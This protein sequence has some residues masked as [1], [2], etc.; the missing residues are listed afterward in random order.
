MRGVRCRWAWSWLICLGA[1]GFI[2]ERAAILSADDA[3]V[4]AAAVRQY[5]LAV[6]LQNKKLYTQAAQKWAAF[7]QGF[8]KDP[9]LPNAH[10]YLGICQ[11]Q[12]N[13]LPEAA[14]SFR[15]VLTMFPTFAARDASQY[16]LGLVLFN[17]AS[18]SKKPEDWKAALDAFAEVNAKFAESKH[19]PSALFYQGEC[20]FSSGD[21][22]AALATYQKF[23]AAYPQNPLLPEVYY[24]LGTTQQG[25]GSDADAV[26]TFQTLVQKFPTDPQ[27]NES[28]LRVGMSQFNQKKYAEAEPIFAQLAAVADFPLADFALLR[29]AQSLSVRAQFPQAAALYETLPMKFPKSKLKGGALLAAGQSWFNA[30]Q[31]PQAQKDLAAVTTEQAEKWEEAPEAAYWLART[32]L[33]LKKPLEAVAELDRAI[34]A[35]AASSFLPQLVFGRIDALYEVPDRQKETVPLFLDFAAKYPD[36]ETAPKALDMAGLA[37]LQLGDFAAAQKHS[38]AFL[39]NAKLAKHELVPDALYVGGESFL[40]AK[41]PDP[42]QAE[43]LFRRLA[44]E[45]PQHKQTPSARVRIGLALH[46]A[47]KYDAAVAH[48]TP[49]VAELKDPPLVAETQLL[50]GRCHSDAGRP[51]PAIIAFRAALVAKPDWDRGDEVLLALAASLHSQKK[52]AE[53]TIELNKLNAAYAQSPFRDQALYQLAEIAYEEKK[54]P[55]AAAH[56]QQVVAQFPKGELAAPAQYGVG[57]SLYS[58]EDFEQAATAFTALLTNWPQSELASKGKFMRGLAYRRL[59]KFDLA[60]KDL[61]EFL[62]AKPSE[63]DAL[64]ARYALALCQVGLKQ[65]EPAATTLAAIIKDKPDYADVDKVYYEMAYALVELKKT[66]EAADAFRQLATKYPASPK[67]AESWFRVGEFH[68]NAKQYVEAAQAYAAGLERTKDA[69][70]LEKLRYK[71]AWVQYQN[72]KYPE[73]LVTLQAQIKEHPQGAL[74]IPAT[75]LAGEALYRQDKLAEALPFYA[76][77]IASKGPGLRPKRH[78]YRSGT[79]ANQLKKWPEGQTHFAALIEQFPKY[80]LIH[81]ARFGLGLALQMQQKLD[82]AKV[83]FEKVTIDTNTEAAA[84]SRFMVGAIAFEQKKYSEAIEH[85]ITT[86]T[87][88]SFEQWQGEANYELGRCFI[89]LK[90]PEQARDALETVVKKF[91]KHSRVKDATTL[92][93]ALKTP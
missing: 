81:D 40:L 15:T 72:G 90:M 66:A 89:E 16:N 86:A 5:N 65:F 69:V 6:G 75:F 8:P 41:P 12:E 21:A 79:C 48:L 93:A 2:A 92:L 88:Y 4:D 19:A 49:L 11:L 37:A 20:A 57:W 1:I 71:Q 22:M 84:K 13:K 27:V 85:Y 10:H 3:P 25:L 23:I 26:A 38:A 17:T 61:T 64:E 34:T 91:P 45:F 53:A 51:D 54:Y 18:A 70:L 29:Q 30:G 9:R 87:G 74:L 36:H 28:K 67:S 31:F 47:K 58:K 32:L 42:A 56:Y 24:A 60:S 68:E 35:C 33:K 7:I 39:A 78:P 46:I 76:Q 63:K 73:A 80:E 52:L 55:E 14:A 83:V 59:M 82:E 77:V 62:A 50:L 43:V 44:T